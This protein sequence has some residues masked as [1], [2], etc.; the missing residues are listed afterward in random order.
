M[1]TIKEYGQDIIATEK[2]NRIRIVTVIGEIEGH[3]VATDSTKTTK[4]EHM[5]PL[6]IAIDHDEQVDGVLFVLNT[7]GGDVE[8]GLA[9]AELIA[10][11]RKPTVSLVIGGSHSIGIPLAVATNDSFIVPTATMLVHPVRMNG[12]LLGAP[13][14]YYQFNQM[15]DRIVSFISSHTKI[16][17]DRLESLMLAK[18]TMA[19]DLGT[20]LVGKNAV[21]E[22]L[23]AHVGD[24]QDAIESLEKKVEE[25]KEALKW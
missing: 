14:T 2:D 12:T 6:L 17:K 5:I 10:S 11:L 19:K 13:Q 21:E 3:T 4:Y 9:L 1:D 8:C 18:D 24:L 16:E 23:I 22:G 15:Q 7:I 20:I 25:K